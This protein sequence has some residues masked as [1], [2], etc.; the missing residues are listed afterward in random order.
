MKNGPPEDSLVDKLIE[1]VFSIPVSE[2][3]AQT[4]N[5]TPFLRIEKYDS[6]PIVRTYLLQLL[7]EH[8]LAN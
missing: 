5:L 6:V 4:R 8:K 2:D 3:K 7:L 1:T